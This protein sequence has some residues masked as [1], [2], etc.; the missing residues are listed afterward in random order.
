MRDLSEL[1]GAVRDLVRHRN[2][3]AAVTSATAGAETLIRTLLA[4]LSDGLYDG[5]ELWHAA[6]CLANVDAHS[7]ASAVDGEGM[8]KS[9]KFASGIVRLIKTTM[10]NAS[11]KLRS[12]AW[13][14]AMLNANCMLACLEIM[15]SEEQRDYMLTMFDDTKAP[16]LLNRGTD[17]WDDFVAA[18]VPVAGPPLEVREVVGDAIDAI[19]HFSFDIGSEPTP[20]TGVAVVAVG[21]PPKHVPV[22]TATDHDQTASGGSPE[23]ASTLSSPA[24][25]PSAKRR[26]KTVKKVV[27]VKRVVRRVVVGGAT[28]ANSDTRSLASTMM[29]EDQEASLLGEELDDNEATQQ[30]ARRAQGAEEDTHRSPRASSSTASYDRDVRP[31]S[32]LRAD[33][34]PFVP[35]PLEFPAPAPSAEQVEVREKLKELEGVAPLSNEM[36]GEQVEAVQT[37]DSGA[38]RAKVDRALDEYERVLTQLE[39][40][41]AAQREALETEVGN[42]A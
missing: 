39:V 27:V 25:P 33:V 15:A 17:L 38:V 13:I 19:I 23:S 26:V 21:T 3:A 7:V 16:V 41:L 14:Q 31:L 22:A 5:V 40:E 42:L 34:A 9:R 4:T 28:D 32:I 24:A 30:Q 8:R 37:V 2:A 11:D 35:P 29:T 12:R 20:E 6:Q 10:A 1:R 18:I 36:D